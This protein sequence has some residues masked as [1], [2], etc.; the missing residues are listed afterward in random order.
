MRS[1]TRGFSGHFSL[2]YWDII[3]EDIVAAAGVFLQGLSLPKAIF[4]VSLILILKTDNLATFSD[5]R[6]ISI[7][8]FFNI[9]IT[10]IMVKCMAHLLPKIIS[11]E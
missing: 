8:K 9:I 2:S 11:I 1:W 4:S 6:P 3:E 7:C 10:K 5:F